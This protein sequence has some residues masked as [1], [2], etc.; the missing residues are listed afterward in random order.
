MVIT[1]NSDSIN[2]IKWSAFVKETQT[3]LCEVQTEFE[4]WANWH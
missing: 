1:V 2:S 4:M 3:F